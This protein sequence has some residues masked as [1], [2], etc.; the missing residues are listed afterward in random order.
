MHMHAVAHMYVGTHNEWMDKMYTLKNNRAEDN[1]GR[2]QM[3][4]GLHLALST[5]MHVPLQYTHSHQYIKKDLLWL[6][7][8]LDPE[9]Y[10]ILTTPF[11]QSLHSS[12]CSFSLCLCQH[13]SPTGA[14]MSALFVS[15][16]S[17][18]Y[19]CPGTLDTFNTNLLS[20]RLK[21]NANKGIHWMPFLLSSW[22]PRVLNW[23]IPCIFLNLPS[24]RNGC[25]SNIAFLGS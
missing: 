16:C 24:G 14:E 25:P 12:T 4:S 6:L 17:K 7:E 20:R 9:G 18:L 5:H 15:V 11:V 3:S 10:Q 1:R 2:Q 21:A 19:S 23:S 22:I 8:T 13:K